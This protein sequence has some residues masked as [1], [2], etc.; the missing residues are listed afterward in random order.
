M[1]YDTYSLFPVTSTVA[2]FVPRLI[3]TDLLIYQDCQN[4]ANTW[5]DFI[6][7]EDDAGDDAVP[8]VSVP[9]SLFIPDTLGRSIVWLR[10]SSSTTTTHSFRRQA[11]TAVAIAT[12]TALFAPGGPA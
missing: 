4:A 8:C 12:A 9:T 3:P 11:Q 5:E 7:K 1:L 10:I 6:V 2:T